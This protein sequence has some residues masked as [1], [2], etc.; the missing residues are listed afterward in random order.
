MLE[1][2]CLRVEISLSRPNETKTPMI[3]MIVVNPLQINQ[4]SDSVYVLEVN[5]NQ[6]KCERLKFTQGQ[7]IYKKDNRY[8]VPTKQK[9]SIKKG[10]NQN[11]CWH[12]RS[13]SSLSWKNTLKT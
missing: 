1:S 7:S 5:K 2:G 11:F 4:A 3:T 9:W 13:H 12:S 10:E 6:E 8:T